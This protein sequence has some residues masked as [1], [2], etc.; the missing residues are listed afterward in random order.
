M[1]KSTEKVSSDSTGE[2][3]EKFESPRQSVANFL[4]YP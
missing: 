2:E 3:K 1:N 4:V